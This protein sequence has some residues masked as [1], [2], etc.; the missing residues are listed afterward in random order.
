MFT[1]TSK[2][3]LLAWTEGR[4]LQWVHW[5]LHPAP[6]TTVLEKK[7][8][9]NFH[10][11]YTRNLTPSDVVCVAVTAHSMPHHLEAMIER[12]GGLWSHRAN[13]AAAHFSHSCWRVTDSNRHSLTS[14]VSTE[15]VRGWSLAVRLDEQGLTWQKCS[16]AQIFYRCNKTSRQHHG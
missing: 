8:Q 15:H 12:V 16:A 10:T 3:L 6:Y 9:S 4:L 13:T 14:S 11:E 7:G 5:H 1:A 2:L